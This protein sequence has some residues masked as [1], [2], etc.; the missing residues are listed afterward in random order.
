[1]SLQTIQLALIN[2]RSKAREWA[3]LKVGLDVTRPVQIYG[4]VNNRCNAKCVMCDVWREENTPE[5]PAATWMN[6]LGAL[7]KFV[8][9]YHINFSGGEPLLK[10]DFHEILAYCKARGILA[11]FT[12]NGL[13]LNGENMQRFLDLGLFN[14]NISIDS[15][16]DEMHDSL[17]GVPGMLEKV[18]ANIGRLVEYKTKHNCDVRIIIK[19]VVF[20]RNLDDLAGIVE[21]ARRMGLTGV[22]FQPVFKWSR[23]SEEMFQVNQDKLSGAVDNLIEMKKNGYDI[24]NSEQSMRQ[25]LSY[26]REESPPRSRPCVVGLRNLTITA[27]GDLYLCGLCESTIGNAVDSDIRTIWYSP[28]AR[29]VRRRLT[30]CKKLCTATC[31]V[32][33]GWRDYFQLF[34]RMLRG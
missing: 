14:I 17:R 31:L 30:Q 2:L 27:A 12:T 29:A 23:Q 13:L 8:G 18:T 9:R 10:N 32:K 11:G 25:W 16:N 5:L 20:N 6:M 21:Y 19:T 28:K 3:Y 22:N 4:L 1:M 24:L 26:F 7:K 15:M 34:L 33:R